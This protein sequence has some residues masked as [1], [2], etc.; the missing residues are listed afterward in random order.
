V[1]GSRRGADWDDRLALKSGGAEGEGRSLGTGGSF[2]VGEGI[3]S[4]VRKGWGDVPGR[5]K[6]STKR[7]SRQES[8]WNGGTKRGGS[9]RGRWR[10]L[11]VGVGKGAGELG[12]D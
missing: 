10:F 1:S 9:L 7:R 2:G 3:T 8:R 12:R 5:R 4:A 11:A 6:G